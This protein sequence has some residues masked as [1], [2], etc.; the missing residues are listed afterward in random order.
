MNTPITAINP[1]ITIQALTPPTANRDAAD[2]NTILASMADGTVV[3]GFV[4]NRDR[5]NN[6]ILRTP[7]GDVL[8]H[9]DIFLKTG[10]EVVFRVDTALASRARIVSIDT[11]TIEEY[12]A[13]A[14]AQPLA[15]DTI[16]APLRIAAKT[17]ENQQNPVLQAVVLQALKT[18]VAPRAAAVPATPQP[19]VPANLV[20]LPSGTALSLTIMDV[21]LPPMPVAV[22][23]LN[24]PPALT[25]LVSSAAGAQSTPP[26]A[27]AAQTAA[28]PTPS[29]TQFPTP[30]VAATALPYTQAS[31]AYQHSATPPVLPVATPTPPS[32]PTPT[33]IPS[34]AA[35]PAPVFTATVIGHGEDGVNILHTR[36][37]TLKLF[38]PQPLPT[39]TVLDIQAEPSTATPPAT[40]TVFADVALAPSLPRTE[41]EYLATAL[42]QL[43]TSDPTLMREV[44]SQF[45]AIGPK[46]VSGLLFF[47]SAVKHGKVR[48]LMG[49]KTSRLEVLA[50]ELITRL[51]KDLSVLQ[52]QYVESPLSDWRPIPLP[53]IFGSSTEPAQL[54]IR[55]EPEESAGGVERIG[56]GHRFLLDLHLSELGDMQ[57]D[58][59]VRSEKSSKSFE[60]VLRSADTLDSTISTDIRTIFSDALAATGLR[61][62][63][64]FQQG[65]ERFIKPS[66]IAAGGGNAAPPHT[67]LA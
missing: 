53:L 9:S 11:M 34:N 48:E 29:P 55:K 1:I 59:F 20:Q 13:V 63:I 42:R 15:K 64:I 36:F 56:S 51:S 32:A 27:P 22:N 21:K 61:G 16:E 6:P 65:A 38:T 14:I 24:L 54:F 47:I 17:L 19:P 26:A 66:A 8:V 41:F 45:P 4:I 30:N 67:I 46:F 35:A 39:G 44:M 23:T 3:K 52:Q 5:N 60:L 33:T 10:S 50:P 40:L 7:Y 49:V 25:Q 12:N 37:A 28:N 43:S 62:Q 18:G 57:L 58:G 2:V 31:N